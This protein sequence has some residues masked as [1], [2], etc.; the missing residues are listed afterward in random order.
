MSNEQLGFGSLDS[1]SYLC[2]CQINQRAVQEA[3]TLVDE[4]LFL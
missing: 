1:L 2:H 4:G 3:L